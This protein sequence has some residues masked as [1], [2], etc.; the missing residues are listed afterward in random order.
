MIK[1]DGRTNIQPFLN[2]V[3]QFESNVV[4]FKFLLNS[5]I[6]DRELKNITIQGVWKEMERHEYQ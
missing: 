1:I 3:R 5:F 6:N 4:V 2:I